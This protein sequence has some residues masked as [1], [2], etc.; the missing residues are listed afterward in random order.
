MMPALSDTLTQISRSM[1]QLLLT[2]NQERSL[3]S[4]SLILETRSWS[5]EVGTLVVLDSSPTG[6]VMPVPMILCTS[7]MLL[8]TSSPPVLATS[9]WLDEETRPWSLCQEERE[10]G[11]PSQKRG[12]E[13]LQTR[14]R[15][16][17]RDSWSTL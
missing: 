12:T 7:R 5:L 3:I 4:S 15:A 10:S 14:Q 13:G 1:T 8:A 6:N 2:S 17:K 11:S 9:S 16:L